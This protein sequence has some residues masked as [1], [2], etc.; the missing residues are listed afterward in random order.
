[1]EVLGHSTIATTAN[2]YVHIL[3]PLH[4]EDA[5]KRMGDLLEEQAG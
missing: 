3:R 2:T 4:H 5:A 1:M